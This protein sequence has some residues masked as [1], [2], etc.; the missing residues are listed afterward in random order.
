MFGTITVCCLSLQTIPG[1]LVVANRAQ[2]TTCL[3]VF[4]TSKFT[5]PKIDVDVIK[6]NAENSRTVEQFWLCLDS[7]I[8]PEGGLD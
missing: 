7:Q 5:V 8:R 3:N 1:S 6:W 4:I 2:I